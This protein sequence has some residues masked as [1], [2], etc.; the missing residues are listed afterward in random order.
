MIN[1]IAYL[2]RVGSRRKSWG[3]RACQYELQFRGKHEPE[4]VICWQTKKTVTRNSKISRC[5]CRRENVRVSFCQYLQLLLCYIAFLFYAIKLYEREC[6]TRNI[7][8]LITFSPFSGERWDLAKKDISLT[9]KENQNYLA[10][11]LSVDRNAQWD[12]SD[13]QNEH[14]CI[15]KRSKW[16]QLALHPNSDRQESQRPIHF[17]RSCPIFKW[18]GL[19]FRDNLCPPPALNFLLIHPREPFLNFFNPICSPRFFQNE[20]WTLDCSLQRG[21]NRRRL[22]QSWASEVGVANARGL[23]RVPNVRGDS[24]IARVVAWARETFSS[25]KAFVP[26][27]KGPAE[28][29]RSSWEGPTEEGGW[30]ELWLW[31]AEQVT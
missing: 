25:A 4:Y 23:G 1:A 19:S 31:Q 24:G 30:R 6:N 18:L 16:M 12:N 27:G 8:F 28:T 22:H 26:E 29:S 2:V 7:T 20:H 13:Y 21:H 17:L 10:H 11:R 5:C 9:V 14:Q 15:M 3:E